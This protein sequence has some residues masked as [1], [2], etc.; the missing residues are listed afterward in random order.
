M[1]YRILL[2]PVLGFIIGYF[3]N[4]LAI[5]MLFYPRK[6]IWGI[7]GILPRQRKEIA[8]RVGEVSVR[9]LPSEVLKVG[10]IPIIGSAVM[11]YLKGS[12]ENQ[13]NS[14]SLDELEDIV[15]KVA[16]KELKFIT[17]IGGVIGFLIGLV[18]V[19]LVFLV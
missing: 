16:R 17:W 14:L 4:Y 9:L 1:D 7:Q 10:R 3:T 18:Q 5:K 12:I 15:F 11:D 13:I 8:K 6:G 2:I 19:G